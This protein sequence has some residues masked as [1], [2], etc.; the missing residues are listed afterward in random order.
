VA[1]LTGAGVGAAAGGL[2][3]AL[4]GAGVGE[5]QAHVYAEGVRRGGSPVVVRTDERRAPEAESILERNAPVDL[6]RRAAEYQA[7]GWSGF[8]RTLLS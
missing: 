7:G 5:E 8:E 4:A 1:T 2:L 6:N 3:G